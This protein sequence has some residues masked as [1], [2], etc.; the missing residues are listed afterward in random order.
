MKVVYINTKGNYADVMTKNVTEA[1]F[2][3]LVPEIQ[4][5]RLELNGQEMDDEE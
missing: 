2:S 4:N 5:G 3:L 1:I